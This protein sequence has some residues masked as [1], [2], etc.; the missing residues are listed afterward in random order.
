MEPFIESE[1]KREIRTKK[2]MK[3]KYGQYYMKTYVL[4][5]NSVLQFRADI[6]V[7]Y[8]EIM[9]IMTRENGELLTPESF[10]YCSRIIHNEL[11]IHNFHAHS[12]RH[13]HGTILAE[14]GVNP[15]TVMERLGHR[16]ISTTL[17]TYIFN[18]DIMQVNTV[19]IFENV[20]NKKSALS[21]QEENGGQSVDKVK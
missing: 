13:T 9:P 14:N 21:T 12:L 2:E 4:P 7:P 17:Q 5:D 3:L 8:K 1:L 6:K 10:K 15:K 19:D 11:G 16:D 20:M 18:T